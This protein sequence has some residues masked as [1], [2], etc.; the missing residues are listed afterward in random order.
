[1]GYVSWDAELG[2]SI[3]NIGVEIQADV[4]IRATYGV[5]DVP[6]GYTEVRY[7]VSVESTA[8]EQDVLHVLDRA[9][10]HGRCRD[11]FGRAQN[12]QREVRNTPPSG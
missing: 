2:V 7:R 11:V 5:A 9:D 6:A 12:L 10:V 1:M 3:S 4:D 8:L